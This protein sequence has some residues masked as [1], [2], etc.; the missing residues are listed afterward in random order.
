MDGVET[1]LRA[2][3]NERTREAYEELVRPCIDA[4]YRTALR[5]TGDSHA[6]EDLVQE[7]CL[8]AFRGFHG[9]ETGTNFKAWLFR[10]LTNACIDS[11]RKNARAPFVDMDDDHLDQ[12]A[13]TATT[14]PAGD[15][16]GPEIHVLYKTFR[17]EAF[18]A[19]AELPP[20]IRIVVALAL[21]K[22]FTYQ[23]IAEV[24]GCPV[25]TVRSRLSRGRQKLQA[26][27]WDYVPDDAEASL[28]SIAVPP[29]KGQKV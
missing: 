25:G 1:G 3:A 17:S 7:T 23:E 16:Q 15:P 10:I 9:Y 8:K 20:D 13:S 14:N 26:A 28:D 2:S 6:A 29:V 11:R 24:A 21:L 27:L 4:L 19:M 12:I 22:E 18:R 5:M